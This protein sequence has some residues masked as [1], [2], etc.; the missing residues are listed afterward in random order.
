MVDKLQAQYY[1]SASR[2]HVTSFGSGFG[3]HAALETGL[4]SALSERQYKP[5]TTKTSAIILKPTPQESANTS[6]SIL[7]PQESINLD[8]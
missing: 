5:K 6:T 3:G 2:F 8:V 1:L 7:K 4:K